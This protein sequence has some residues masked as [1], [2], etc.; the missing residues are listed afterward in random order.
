M[1]FVQ[2]LVTKFFPNAQ[3]ESEDW[4]VRCTCGKVRSVWELGGVRF[5]AKGNPHRLLKCPAC[6]ET[7]WHSVYRKGDEP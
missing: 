2:R 7:T 1:T 3:I 5:K 6:G 4:M